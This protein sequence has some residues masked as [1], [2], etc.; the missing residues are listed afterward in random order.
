MWR[1]ARWIILL[2]ANQDI[3]KVDGVRLCMYANDGDLSCSLHRV[4][5][6]SDFFAQTETQ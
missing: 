4:A 3:M 6:I 1:D 5:W 2:L